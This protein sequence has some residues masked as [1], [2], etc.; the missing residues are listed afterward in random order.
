MRCYVINMRYQLITN[1]PPSKLDVVQYRKRGIQLLTSAALLTLPVV[2]PSSDTAY[3]PS[4][5]FSL[6]IS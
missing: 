6:E 3:L 2:A 5:C 4:L 1:M